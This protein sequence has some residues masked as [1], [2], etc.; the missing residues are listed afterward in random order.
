MESHFDAAAAAYVHSSAEMP[1]P[2]HVRASVAGPRPTLMG[3]GRG[4]E[5]AL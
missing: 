5:V 1:L 2:E 4:Q 3:V